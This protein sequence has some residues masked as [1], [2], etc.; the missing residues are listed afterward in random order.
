MALAWV[1]H[2]EQ[3]NRVNCLAA[4]WAARICDGDAAL[5]QSRF[6]MVALSTEVSRYASPRSSI[7]E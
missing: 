7:G 3:G 4:Y 5:C 2:G 1:C 6:L